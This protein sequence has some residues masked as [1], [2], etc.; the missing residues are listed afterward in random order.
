MIRD[1][2]FPLSDATGVPEPALRLLLALLFGYP[3]AMVYRLLFLPSSSPTPSPNS[4]PQKSFFLHSPFW[5]NLYIVVGGMGVAGFFS[6]F[7]ASELQHAFLTI[8]VTWSIIKVSFVSGIPR[9]FA[10]SLIWIGNFGYL[11]Y[12]YYRHASTTY[13]INFLTPQSVLCLRMISLGMDFYDGCP[14]AAKKKIKDDGLIVKEYERPLATAPGLFETLGYSYFYGAFLVGPQFPFELYRRYLTLELFDES[15]DKTKP[16]TCVTV[17]SSLK[18]TL[19]CFLLGAFY[20]ALQQVANVFFPTS[21]LID[22]AFSKLPFWKKIAWIWVVGKFVLNKV[23]L[24]KHSIESARFT[25]SL[26]P[27]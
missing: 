1:F 6:R 27:Y 19:R 23:L 8:L 17:P 18:Y 12:C 2:V 14:K 5:R 11:M 15:P 21:F 4:S 13:D 26:V 7:D 16:T 9:S 3:L 25:Y 10:A 22:S 20:L 24:L